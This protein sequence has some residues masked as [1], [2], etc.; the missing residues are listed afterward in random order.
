LEGS[1]GQEHGKRRR[2]KS[3]TKVEGKDIRKERTYLARLK[4]TDGQRPPR[5]HPVMIEGVK[6][7]GF[8]VA[9]AKRPEVKVEDAKDTGNTWV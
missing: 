3:G 6:V 2:K 4:H 5:T 8:P 7:V 1:K 9:E